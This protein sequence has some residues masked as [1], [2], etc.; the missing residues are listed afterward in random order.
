MSIDL[1]NIDQV[2]SLF[3]QLTDIQIVGAKGPQIR[4]SARSLTTNQNVYLYITLSEDAMMFGWTNQ[5]IAK[6]QNIIHI[7]H[8]GLLKII[9]AD[10]KPDL[11]YVIF[12]NPSSIKLEDFAHYPKVPAKIALQQVRTIALGVEKLHIQ[13]LYHGAIC[14]KSIML[15][16]TGEHA[17]L[18]PI[19]IHPTRNLSDLGS[20][21]SPE[22]L[23]FPN[24]PATAATDIYALGILL[25]VLLTGQTPE[26]TNF[27]MPSSFTACSAK[28]DAIVAKATA[29]N[30]TERYTN[31]TELIDAIEEAIPE[32]ETGFAPVSPVKEL[33]T[34]GSAAPL[35]RPIQKKGSNI[36]L[37]LAI[38]L[39]IIAG[40]V[41][42]VTKPSEFGLSSKELE[43][44][45]NKIEKTAKT[46][47]QVATPVA[48]EPKKEE[49][50]VSETNPAESDATDIVNATPQKPNITPPPPG[51]VA[52]MKE[53]GINWI[54]SPDTKIVLSSTKSP[55]EDFGIEKLR[56]GNISPQPEQKSITSTD[57]IAGK[58][59]WLGINFGP[60][61]N[62][63]INKIVLYTLGSK[64]TIGHMS[65][66]TIELLDN[67]K[68]V[69][70]EREFRCPEDKDLNRMVW[71][72][73]APEKVRAILIKSTDEACPVIVSEVEVY[74]PSESSTPNRSTDETPAKEDDDDG[75]L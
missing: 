32:A 17:K 18:L 24:Q 55:A 56:D 48:E 16:S 46:I 52:P 65:S 2:Q 22:Q 38:F 1:T 35:P 47:A 72:L 50:T 63:E 45:S 21:A 7:N 19:N 62:R 26:Q 61:H 36:W 54:K 3:P 71:T 10:Q 6:A 58:K 29:P 40:I 12:E 33:A 28:V 75:F 70:Q 53:G 27:A 5:F 30:P 42:A 67:E 69:L 20:F 8:F 39:I 73:D 74:G 23:A 64:S 43:K 34:G 44:I 13:H 66:F 60:K 57:V 68:N 59:A 9:E 11:I 25:Y 14:P 31:V 41:Y 15:D 37:L 49:P 4:Y 51:P